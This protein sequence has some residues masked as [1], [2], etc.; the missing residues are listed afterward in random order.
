MVNNATVLSEP[1]LY[2]R[3][4]IP[5]TVSHVSNI[6]NH[7]RDGNMMAVRSAVAHDKMG[8]VTMTIFSQLT[9]EVADGKSYQF[10]NINVGCYK[11]ER[12]LKTTEMTKI[13]SIEDL[14][15][16]IYEHDVTPNTVT[17]DGKFISVQLGGLTIV[18]QCPKCYSTVDIKDEMA[19][20]DHCSTVSAED[21]CSSKCEVGCTVMNTDMKVKYNVAVPRSCACLARRKDY[22]CK[23]PIKRYLHF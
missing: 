20:C 2:D 5:A 19:I 1:A 10:T 4:N 11:K 9:N 8:F 16:N 7:E 14:D 3:F 15:V 17:F 23:A 13:T 22:V 12:V 18:Y 21:Q 6:D